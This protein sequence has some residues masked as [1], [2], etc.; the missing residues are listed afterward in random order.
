MTKQIAL[1][2]KFFYFL[3]AKTVFTALLSVAEIP[4][5]S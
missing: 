3:R 4:I 1:L 5:K 2:K